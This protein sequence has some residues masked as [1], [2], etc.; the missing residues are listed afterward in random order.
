MQIEEGKYYKDRRGEIQGPMR[1]GHNNNTKYPWEAGDTNE[2]FTD[3]GHYTYYELQSDYDLVEEYKIPEHYPNKVK[4]EDLVN[5][6]SHYTSHPSGIECIEITR[7][8]DFAVGNAMK[9]IWRAGLK[10]SSPEKEIEDL[11]KAIWYLKDKISLLKS[12]V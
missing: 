10:D 6:P 9:Y 7:H 8:H 2:W 12:K 4:S 5:H 11:E 3:N 1:T